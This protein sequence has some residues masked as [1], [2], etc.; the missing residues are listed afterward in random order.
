MMGA[1]DQDIKAD[2]ALT[3]PQLYGVG[4]RQEA[5]TW[6]IFMADSCEGLY[7]ACII[8]FFATA[9][10]SQVGIFQGCQLD[11]RYI[12]NVVIIL[13]TMWI[14]NISVFLN[15]QSWTALPICGLIFEFVTTVG[16][17]FILSAT[18]TSTAYQAAPFIFASGDFWLVFLLVLV[19]CLLP[20]L[21]VKYC[22][23]L[24]K[25]TDTQI[26]KE[27]EPNRRGL[28]E[29]SLLGTYHS[30]VRLTS[31]R[32]SLGYR[33]PLT[34]RTPAMTSVVSRSSTLEVTDIRFLRE[35]F[36]LPRDTGSLILLDSILTPTASPQINRSATSAMSP[37]GRRY[38][39]DY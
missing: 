11:D 17:T 14:S 13:Y 35:S 18:P 38:P 31:S 15:T 20:R 25:P 28:R 3:V 39:E 37:F 32:A 2:T 24:W 34:I 8:Y 19:T 1:F 36:S 21:V 4:I 9:A 12:S 5:L 7:H 27:I 22:L 10:H 26:A 30:M 29:I 6:T 23:L 16:Y 33:S